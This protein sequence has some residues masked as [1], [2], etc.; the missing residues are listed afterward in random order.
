MKCMKS[1]NYQMI[2]LSLFVDE[3]ETAVKIFLFFYKDR[4]FRKKSFYK[5]ILSYGNEIS[6]FSRKYLLI[7]SSFEQGIL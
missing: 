5:N 3:L 1:H 2:D 4:I 6:V 7:F